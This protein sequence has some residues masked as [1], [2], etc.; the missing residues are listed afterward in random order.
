MMV[1]IM[2]T[3]A[4]TTRFEGLEV[5]TMHPPFL[6]SARNRFLGTDV[7]VAAKNNGGPTQSF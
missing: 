2:L 7:Y 3:L 5:D 1:L 4:P 6:L